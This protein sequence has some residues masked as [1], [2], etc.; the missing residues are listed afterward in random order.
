MSRITVTK[1]VTTTLH[2]TPINKTYYCMHVAPTGWNLWGGCP[3]LSPDHWCIYW[4]LYWLVWASVLHNYMILNN[5]NN[6]T[7]LNQ[8]SLALQIANFFITISWLDWKTFWTPR[9]TYMYSVTSLSKTWRAFTRNVRF[10][11]L[12][13]DSYINHFIFW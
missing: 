11:I 5:L 10:H 3:P 12:H 13:I 1:H 4:C 7:S 8:W 9:V 2:I 6:C